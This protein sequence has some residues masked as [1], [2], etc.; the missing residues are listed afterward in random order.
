MVCVAVRLLVKSYVLAA[1]LAVALSVIVY[2]ACL[3]VL[4]NEFTLGFLQPILKKKKK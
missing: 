4:K 3:I 1:V 2:G